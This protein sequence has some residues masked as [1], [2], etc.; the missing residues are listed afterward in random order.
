MPNFQEFTSEV[1]EKKFLNEKTVFLKLKLLSP[2]EINFQAGQYVT[3]KINEKT[4]RSYSI[5]SSPDQKEAIN[6]IIDITPGGPGS[7]FAK[8]AKIGEQV[9]FIG[10]L[11]KFVF[12]A[13][14]EIKSVY[15]IATGCGVA[16]IHS[17]ILDIFR[18]GG[19]SPPKGAETAP[20]QINLLFGC[21]YKQDFV[22]WDEYRQLEKDFPNFKFI[23]C[24]SREQIDGEFNGR[25]TDYLKKY[26]GAPLA[27][28]QGEA[29]GLPLQNSYFYIC[30]GR[31]MVNE[32]NSILTSKG[33]REEQI[34]TERY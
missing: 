16:P 10:P 19:V 2:S 13:T 6:L 30:G 21:S 23:P 15:F 29:Q 26:V 28:A 20:L 27:G 22:A 24:V 34:I 5:Y 31:E 7:Q 8:N 11:G 33:V 4:P 14:P 12:S 3:I 25:V 18:R 32:T 17:M 1:S 9:N